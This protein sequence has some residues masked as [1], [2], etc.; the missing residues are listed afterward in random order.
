MTIAALQL[1]AAPTAGIVVS[2]LAEA[3][4]FFAGG[5]RSITFGSPV[6][7]WFEA[8]RPSCRLRVQRVTLRSVQA[9]PA[10]PCAFSSWLQPVSVRCAA[11]RRPPSSNKTP[12][13]FIDCA[14]TLYQL[15]DFAVAHGWRVPVLI[16]IDAGNKRAGVP[17]SDALDIAAAVSELGK[18]PGA[19]VELMGI[20][21]H[22]GHAYACT[23]LAESQACA[24]EECARMGELCARLE[25]AGVRVPVVSIGSVRLVF[26]RHEFCL[27]APLPLG[28]RLNMVCFSSDASRRRP[29]PQPPST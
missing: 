4:H 29:L 11:A 25:A 10:L 21:S 16:K 27:R 19:G 14:A 3:E 18:K 17:D 1:Q 7:P 5:Q 9:L 15:H 24:A 6:I 20:Y 8:L 2:T 12:N 26:T 13:R 23:C 28:C 22:S